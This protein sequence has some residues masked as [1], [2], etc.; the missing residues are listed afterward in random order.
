MKGLK[1]VNYEASTVLRGQR[2]RLP[3]V[4]PYE[5]NIEFML[6]DTPEQD[7]GYSFIV[8]T[9]VK[10]GLALVRL[11]NEAVSSCKKG[12]N[13]KWLIDNWAHWIYPKCSVKSVYIF[14]VLVG[15]AQ[16]TLK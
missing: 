3:A 1:L 13:T 14:G 5:K 16:L 7:G 15:A 10:A 12:V 2:L 8:S 11:P 4:W 6:V 9:G